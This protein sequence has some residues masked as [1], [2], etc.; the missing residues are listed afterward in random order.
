MRA[1]E[2]LFK[3]RVLKTKSMLSLRNNTPSLCIR[4]QAQN[5]RF[6]VKELYGFSVVFAQLV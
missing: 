3:K 1:I 6:N 5:I 4:E 2:L